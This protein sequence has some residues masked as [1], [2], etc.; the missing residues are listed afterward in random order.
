MNV[1]LTQHLA[2]FMPLFCFFLPENIRKPAI[3]L[4]FQKLLKEREEA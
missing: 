4:C 1:N 2:H 3:F